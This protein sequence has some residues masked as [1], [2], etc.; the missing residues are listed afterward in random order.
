MRET[1][2][3]PI[4]IRP[5]HAGDIPALH[6]LVE[7]AY[8][9]ESAKRGWTHEADLLAGQ[10]TDHDDL[11]ETIAAPDKAILAACDDGDL[12]GCV[13]VEARADGFGYLGMLSVAP[14]RQGAGLGRCLISAA[15]EY[16]R[17]RFGARRMMMTV[18]KQ[19]LELIAYYERRGWTLTGAEAAFPYGDR[20]FGDPKTVDLVFVV[21]ERALA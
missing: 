6:A 17:T 15:E 3:M 13:R 10:R 20:R 2:R 11:A 19:R 5:A 7:G 21:L 18:I 1:S 9:G 4:T 16:A 12:V 8:R 14:A